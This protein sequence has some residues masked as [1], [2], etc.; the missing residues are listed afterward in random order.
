MFVALVICELH[1][2]FHINVGIYT[3]IHDNR[4]IVIDGNR[5]HDVNVD[6]S[7]LGRCWPGFKTSHALIQKNKYIF[8]F[9]LNTVQEPQLLHANVDTY[10]MVI[11]IEVCCQAEIFGEVKEMGKGKVGST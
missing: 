6:L 3:K 2:R 5:K 11:T 8:I 9:Y 10:T 1:V 4:F 7:S